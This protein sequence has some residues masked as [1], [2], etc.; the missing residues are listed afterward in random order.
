M[1]MQE[2]FNKL[3][4]E[5]P[6][7]EVAQVIKDVEQ[8]REPERIKQR[9]EEEES[10]LKQQYYNL[11]L[12]WFNTEIDNS[13]RRSY[14]YNRIPIEQK[15]ETW[16]KALTS[17]N[18]KPSEQRTELLKALASGMQ[19]ETD[20]SAYSRYILAMMVPD[21][22]GHLGHQLL[23]VNFTPQATIF[24]EAFCEMSGHSREQKQQ[25]KN[26]MAA[27]AGL[28]GKVALPQLFPGI[29]RW[30]DH[31]ASLPPGFVKST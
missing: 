11:G 3:R 25:F 29:S 2:A 22:L 21:P 31:T 26:F 6:N 14:G 28:T 18:D 16:T 5:H 27:E 30:I 19:L 20:T 23:G 15:R 4:K 17:L 24:M 13:T 1:S 8:A 9:Q 10:E 7:S 12:M